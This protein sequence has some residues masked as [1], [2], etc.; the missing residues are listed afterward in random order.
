LYFVVVLLRSLLG[1]LFDANDYDVA[2][3]LRHSANL[4]RVFDEGEGRMAKGFYYLTLSKQIFE[5]IGA[6]NDENYQ[7]AL[8]AI[9][10][11]YQLPVEKDMQHALAQ[12][13][14][15]KNWKEGKQCVTQ[16]KYG[17]ITELIKDFMLESFK[18]IT[19]V[20]CSDESSQEGIIYIF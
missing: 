7:M 4:S 6:V 5:R 15:N 2:C 14:W 13:K 12:P 9:G 10:G 19:A 18:T 1:E 8:K 20:T 11:Y 3:V 16:Y 17:R